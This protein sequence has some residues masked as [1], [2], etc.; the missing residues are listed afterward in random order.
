MAARDTER[1][2]WLKLDRG[3]FKRHDIT[4]IESMPNG[5]DYV[6]LYL[7]LM[8]ESVDHEGAL[9]F[10]D[11]V[12]YTEEML[13]SITHL[14]AS[15]VHS[16]LELF[17]SLQ[18]IEV[19]DDETLFIPM[20]ADL[21]DSET[22][23]AK[24]KREQRKDS[25]KGDIVPRLSPDCPQLSPK[26]PQE[27]EKEIETEKESEQEKEKDS[28]TL[29]E[30]SVCR[31]ETVRRVIKAWNDLGIQNIRKVPPAETKVGQMLRARIREYG[32]DAVL[33]AVEKVRASDFLMGKAS[34]W[35]ITLEWFSR[36]NNFPKVING[37]Y[38]NRAKQEPNTR[39]G[40]EMKSTY[41]MMKKWSEADE[42]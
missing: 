18:M 34:D 12:P 16:G 38:D 24:R 35:Q 8:C 1:Y 19:F 29:S 30:E 14:D 25:E 39:K 40:R 10:S 37:N 31:P 23:A 6:L 11:A 15:L 3:F 13:S 42:S 5:R 22:Y 32:I 7:K 4:V 20:V 27:K 33:E 41:D 21:L 28:G 26:C 17:K 36:P 2:Y 9:R